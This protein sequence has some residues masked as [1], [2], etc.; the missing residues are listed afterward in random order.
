MYFKD[1]YRYYFEQKLSEYQVKYFYNSYY[2]HWV[3]SIS[4]LPLLKCIRQSTRVSSFFQN[5]ISA[6]KFTNFIFNKNSLPCYALVSGCIALLILLH[7]SKTYTKN[8]NIK[9]YYLVKKA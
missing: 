7:L 4:M 1:E 6:K 2:T 8:S 3:Y 9:E 5:F